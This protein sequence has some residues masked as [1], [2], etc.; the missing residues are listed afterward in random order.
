MISPHFMNSGR[1]LFILSLLDPE[2]R[3][4]VMDG[5]FS[6]RELVEDKV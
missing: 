6:F 2:R 5:I 3:S 1:V 4:K